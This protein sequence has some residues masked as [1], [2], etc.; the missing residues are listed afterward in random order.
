MRLMQ[1]WQEACGAFERVVADD[2]AAKE[3]EMDW[4]PQRAAI[5]DIVNR[6]LDVKHEIDSVVA[7]QNSDDVPK[8]P[9]VV[10]IVQ[11]RAN[12]SAKGRDSSLS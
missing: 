5:F 3:L 7:D 1:K 11:F 8:G 10:G 12:H 4:R 6:L 9:F 2:R